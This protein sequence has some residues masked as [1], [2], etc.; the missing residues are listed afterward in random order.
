MKISWPKISCN[1]QQVLVVGL[2]NI[3]TSMTAKTLT[4]CGL[5][6][7]PELTI[8]FNNREMGQKEQMRNLGMT[9]DNNDT[10]PQKS[11]TRVDQH[12]TTHKH[13]SF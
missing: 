13:R 3:I 10:P 6:I 9:N 1:I 11:Q 4:A 8:K 5:I 7:V 2:V 12:H